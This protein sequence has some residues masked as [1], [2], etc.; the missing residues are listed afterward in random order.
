VGEG[1]REEEEEGKEEEACKTHI[2][3]LIAATT[4]LSH[5]FAITISRSLE[6][7]KF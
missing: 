6:H 4:C 2:I 5:S 3:L 1:E 7:A